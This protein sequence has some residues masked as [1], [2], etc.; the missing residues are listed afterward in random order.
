MFCKKCGTRNLNI[1]KFCENCGSK[2]IAEGTSGKKD[3]S[4]EKPTGVSPSLIVAVA[5]VLTV[6]IGIF[7]AMSFV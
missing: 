1:A 2:L 4:D 3:L 5:I 6:V 7:I